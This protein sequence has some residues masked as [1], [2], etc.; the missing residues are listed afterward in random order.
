MKSIGIKFPFR[1]TQ[2][3][4]IIGVTKTEQEKIQS[5]L[6]AFLTLQKGQRVMHNDLY[7]P[8]YDFIMET[9]DEITE[10]DL[11]DALLLSLEKFF[12]E[13]KT[14]TIVFDFNE[15]KNLLNIKIT[16]EIIDLNVQDSVEIAL[17]LEQ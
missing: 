13:I 16:Y 14:K 10:S 8:L 5:N 3:G 6:I 11:S 2:Q 15:E 9:W 7:S 12:I 4:G 1:E 17:P